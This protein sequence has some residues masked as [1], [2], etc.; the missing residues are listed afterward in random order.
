MSILCNIYFHINFNF[1]LIYFTND[2]F[3]ELG[4]EISH[5]MVISK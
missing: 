5:I 3:L 4:S 1:V 2:G